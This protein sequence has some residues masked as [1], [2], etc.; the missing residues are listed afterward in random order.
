MNQHPPYHRGELKVQQLAKEESIAQRNGRVITNQIIAGA[1]PFIAQQNMIVLTSLDYCGKVWTSLLIGDTG[2]I[3]APDANSLIIDTGKLVTH[4]DDVLWGNIQIN[5]QVGLLAIELSTRRRLRVNGTIKLLD[6][7]HFKIAV[8]QAF[9]NCPK[10]IQRRRLKVSNSNSSTE[11]P[12]TGEQLNQQQIELIRSSDS[13][14]VGS[15][16]S[17]VSSTEDINAVLK[18]QQITQFGCD[19]SHRGGYPGFVDVLDGNRL[20]IPDYKGNSMFNTLGNIEVYPFAGMVLVDFENS[21]LLQLSGRAKI[22]WDQEDPMNKTAGTQRFWELLVDA[23]QETLLPDGINWQFFDYSPHNP[24]ESQPEEKPA[25]KVNAELELK[26]VNVEQKSERIKMF[27]MV[28]MQG[29]LLPAFEPGAHLP[30]EIVLASGQKVERYYSLLS[31]S[32]DN[33]FYE[34]AVQKESN[35]RGG[36]NFIHQHFSIGSVIKARPPRN[37][38]PLSPVSEHTVLIAGGIGITPI[39]S[40]LRALVEREASFEIHYSAR[41]QSEMGFSGEVKALAGDRAHFYFSNEK[42]SERLKLKKVMKNAYLNSH[43]FI[44]GPTRMIEAVKKFW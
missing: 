12:R 21:K 14:F 11:P 43:L 3:H 5:S 33:R 10:Y 20:R 41:S 44:C 6:E 28:S 24:R 22:L 25:H 42:N 40:M 30:V 9:P 4:P 35:G 2:F 39:L 8:E 32:S 29:G 19:A 15:A 1:I 18:S 37:E 38:F 7:T 17:K 31:S 34:I 36:S 26:V 13:F 16:S 23:W 27:R